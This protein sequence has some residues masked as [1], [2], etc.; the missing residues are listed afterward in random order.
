[1]KKIAILILVVSLSCYS[2]KSTISELENQKKE[3]QDKIS[4]LSDSLKDIEL[5]INRKKSNK[6]IK[7]TKDSSLVAEVKKGGKL[8]KEPS[9]IG[10]IIFEFDKEVDVKV[11]DY[12][13]GYYKICYDSNCGYLS[14]IWIYESFKVKKF[15]NLKVSEIKEQKQKRKKAIARKR[16]NKLKKKYISK[17][18]ERIYTKLKNGYYWIGMDKE[19]A[20]ISLGEPNDINRTVTNYGVNEQWVYDGIYLYFEDDVLTSFQD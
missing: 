9:P 2:Q 15:K 18:G 19:M 8:K 6:L 4:K 7:S 1:M 12:K 16:S 13:D 17:Y 14:E 5:R 10:S 11:L 3:I 20:K